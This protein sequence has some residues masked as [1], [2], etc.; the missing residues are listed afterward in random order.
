[1]LRKQAWIINRTWKKRVGAYLEVLEQ[2]TFKKLMVL[3][4]IHLFRMRKINWI[5]LDFTLLV[6]LKGYQRDKLYDINVQESKQSG[7]RTDLGDGWSTGW[8]ACCTS[9]LTYWQIWGIRN[10]KDLKLRAL[11]YLNEFSNSNKKNISN[12]F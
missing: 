10:T 11:K 1:M 5:K 12:M 8:K 4:H 6:L 2:Q 3:N 7:Q 9:S